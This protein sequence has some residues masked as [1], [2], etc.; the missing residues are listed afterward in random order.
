MSASVVSMP[1]EKR[2]VPSGAVPSERCAAGEQW[3]PAR[4]MTPHSSSSS[5]AAVAHG[6]P[7]MFTETIPTLSAGSAEP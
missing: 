7:S 5:R 2:I 6:T 1:Q 3:R 4:V